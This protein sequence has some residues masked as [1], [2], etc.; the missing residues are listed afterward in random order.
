MNSINKILAQ[1]K[2][3]TLASG[4]LLALA[5]GCQV[6]L[7]QKQ[8]SYIK[9]L[10]ELRDKMSG[11]GDALGGL[12][13][14]LGGLGDKLAIPATFYVSVAMP[15]VTAAL[16]ILI[17]AKLALPIGG[18]R[19]VLMGMLAFYA[20]VGGYS[21]LN[22]WM[23]QNSDSAVIELLFKPTPVAATTI[24][25]TL[26]TPCLVLL[27]G[28]IVNKGEAWFRLGAAAV[29]LAG[30]A[31]SLAQG[32]AAA[33]EGRDNVGMA[34]S[35]L[36]PTLVAAAILL[37]PVLKESMYLRPWDRAEPQGKAKK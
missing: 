12:L 4:I 13:G 18:H 7:I 10:L 35:I 11:I 8:I 3:K 32:L 24:L 22:T 36:A 15:I 25:F 29:S 30:A 27:A 28:L 17:F 26:V 6:Y 31:N 14:G 21:L 16:L 33:G 1:G 20:L 9:G 5:A 34:L 19:F 37:H 2:N 23:L